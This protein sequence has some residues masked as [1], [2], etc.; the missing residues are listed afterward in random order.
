MRIP[1]W[2]FALNLESYRRACELRNTLVANLELVLM[3]NRTFNDAV[4]TSWLEGG[5]MISAR[6]ANSQVF[7]AGAETVLVAQVSAVTA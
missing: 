4:S 2:A 6:D 1:I 7:V 3:E 5:D